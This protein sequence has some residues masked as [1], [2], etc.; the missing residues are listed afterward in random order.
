MRGSMIEQ[1]SSQSEAS[2]PG[3]NHP[4]NA[5]MAAIAA[6]SQRI[7]AAFLARHRRIDSMMLNIVRSP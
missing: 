3:K 4:D 5:D 7:V 6:R 2:D 1:S